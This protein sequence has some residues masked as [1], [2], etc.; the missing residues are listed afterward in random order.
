MESFFKAFCTIVVRTLYKSKKRAALHFTLV[1]RL[2]CS[3]SE[4]EIK[5]PLLLHVTYYG[6]WHKCVTVM[7]SETPIKG[8]P[9]KRTPSIK[10]TLSR[11]PK[12]TSYIFLY[13][14]P[15]F[16]GHLY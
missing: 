8:L 10:R 14:E 1:D 15:L 2:A 5:E 16:S 12:L 11:V 3:F 13:N 7:Y 4:N 6:R 9:I